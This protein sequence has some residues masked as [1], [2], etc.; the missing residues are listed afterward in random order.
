MVLT[1]PPSDPAASV[2]DALRSLGLTKYEARVYMA[3]LGVSGATATEIHEISDVPRASVYSVLDRLIEKNLVTISHTTP[4]RFAAISPEDGISQLM[5]HIEANAGIAS[6]A[7]SEIHEKQIDLQKGAQEG[8]WSIQGRKHINQRLRSLLLH[9]EISVWLFASR[10]FMET[11]LPGVIDEIAET[12]RIEVLTDHWEGR[13]RPDMEVRLIG[14]LGVHENMPFHEASGVF[15]ID[16]K[17]VMLVMGGAGEEDSSAL[18]SESAGFIIF[19]R[20]Y[21]DVIR[22]WAKVRVSSP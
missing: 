13:S 1:D 8:I 18:L 12:V 9:A 22:A 16:D 20:R 5:Q 19:F 15:I 7:L 14:V 3:L 11:S 10:K 21:R 4:K 17:I 2:I 6:K